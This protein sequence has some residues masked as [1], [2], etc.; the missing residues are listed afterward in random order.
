VLLSGHLQGADTNIELS[1]EGEIIT[2]K[3]VAAN[4]QDCTNK[5]W[6]SASVDV[7]WTVYFIKMHR[8]NNLK[9]EIEH[10]MSSTL[11]L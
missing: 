1:D 7:T 8:I 11:S 5:I 4:V 3:H 2:R 6:N 10:K 9:F